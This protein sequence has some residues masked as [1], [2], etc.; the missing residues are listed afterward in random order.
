MTLT[1]DFTKKENPTQETEIFLFTY[2]HALCSTASAEGN[3]P[4]GELR[5]IPNMIIQVAI[6]L[7]QIE[8]LCKKCWLIEKK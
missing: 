4:P 7:N 1:E 3:D 2:T 6:E 5:F 8:V